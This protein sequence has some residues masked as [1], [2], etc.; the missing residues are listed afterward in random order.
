MHRLVRFWAVGF[1]LCITLTGASRVARAQAPP[2][3]VE[4]SLS[5][6]SAAV[7]PAGKVLATLTARIQPGWHLYSLTTPKGGP[8]AT[9]VKFPES[10]AIADV[11]MFQPMPL[12]T[13]DPNF[14]LDTETFANEVQ[15]IAEMTLKPNARPGTVHLEAQI[16]YQACQDKLCLPPKTK[17]ADVTIKIDPNAE[18]QRTRIPG[19]YAEVVRH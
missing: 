19:G 9:T 12:R 2:D 3:P 8:N 18:P 10:P 1:L 11:K 14:K 16:R 4:W 5:V 17:M 6:K 15:L 13:Y 7:R